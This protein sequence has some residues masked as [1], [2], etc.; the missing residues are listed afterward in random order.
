MQNLQR[1]QISEYIWSYSH[2]TGRVF[3]ERL[4]LLPNGKIYGYDSP[5]L[6]TW[7]LD[8]SQIL[9]YDREGGLSARLDR[10]G[11]LKSRLKAHTFHAQ[12]FGCDSK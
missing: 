7:G 4:K 5:N 12:I 3:S 1:E 9:L 2:A 11:G 10:T 6:F 8:N